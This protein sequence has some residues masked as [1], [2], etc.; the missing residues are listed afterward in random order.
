MEVDSKKIR[1][2]VLA[3]L[4]V[5]AT[6]VAL[7]GN[8][9]ALVEPV[10]GQ[11][12]STVAEGQIVTLYLDINPSDYVTVAVTDNPGYQDYYS[13][14]DIEPMLIRNGIPQGGSYN[15]TVVMLCEGY[16][17]DI[18]GNVGGY[19]TNTFRN[20][21]PSTAHFTGVYDGN[22][23]I[24]PM[25][26]L[27]QCPGD[28]DLNVSEIDINPACSKVTDELFA[29][30]TNTIC[31]T[32][33]NNGTGDASAFNVS[34]VI[35]GYRKVVRV[36]GLNA[37]ES[38]T[39]CID[40][41]HPTAPGNLMVNVTADCDSEV[42]ETDEGNNSKVMA[43][44]VYNN[45]YKGKRW[46]GG[47]DIVTANYHELRGN[48]TYSTGDSQYLSGYYNPDWTT[49]MVNWTAA[50]LPVPAGALIEKARLYL[51][52]TW[53]KSQGGN[54]TD[55]FSMSF[56]G[57]PVSAD[58]VY[59]DRKMFGSSDY[60]AQTVAYDVRGAFIP[61]APNHAVLTN[62]YP[63]GGHVSIYGM[64]LVVIYADSNEAKKLFW[65]NE[66]SDILSADKR[67]CVDYTEATAYAPFN[68]PIDPAKIK[69]ARLIS[70]VTAGDT[71]SGNKQQDRLY[72]NGNQ[73]GADVFN[74]GYKA[75]SIDDR[76]VDP[77]LLQPSNEV[78]IQSYDGTYERGDY[79]EARNAFL[80][81]EQ[82]QKVT[83]EMDDYE[84]ST[85]GTMTAPIMINDIEDYGAA[86]ITLSYDP[87]VVWVTE[88]ED[89]PFS[90]VQA[91][92]I[93]NTAGT[94]IISA[95]NTNGV[96]GDI[97]F[98]R[99]T[100]E[101]VGGD[102]A[103]TDLGLNV[104][105]LVDTGYNNL[106]YLVENGSITL[107][108]NVP[109]EISN[110]TANPEKIIQTIPGGRDRPADRAISTLSV[111]VVDTGSGVRCV[112]IDLSP[113]GGSAATVMSNTGGN[114]YSVQT[115][116]TEGIDQTHELLVTAEDKNG[117]TATSTIRLE[118]LR[119]G[120]VVRDNAVDMG[121]ALYIARYTV[122]LES[123]AANWVLV[124][125]VVG[126]AGDPLGDNAVDMA[127]ALYISR[128]T[129]GLELEP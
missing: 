19:Y 31:A 84:M 12:N 36:N 91:F 45:G 53:D 7:V 95:Q 13:F 73:I 72:F 129:V 104:Q 121:D 87:G 9:V 77:A 40:D 116:A 105:K 18:N 76:S 43:A 96:S 56:N 25:M 34:F 48:I 89:G 20:T 37:S 99:V 49:Y 16:E 33:W 68:G 29:N 102:G 14:S 21:T 59:A 63:G 35:D 86:T 27:E 107:K 120:D 128:Y 97:E 118:V 112:T 38:K 26:E 88:V 83:V 65:I 100:F 70:I 42:G 109:P 82:T 10:G 115:N 57:N 66:G 94:V 3:L 75:I 92:N 103:M 111:D 41:Y 28:P 17:R 101:A 61:N 6:F 2:G 93:D 64:L 1:G 22:P 108:E 123:E 8:A 5:T 78:S 119:R 50:D 23:E 60:P 52:T 81:L 46:T 30:E 51:Y 58:R 54:I 24:P 62:S 113:I 80:V 114:T 110:E 106:P 85:P 15:A 71:G 11:V 4:M 90:V 117:N 124:G 44:T 39:V 55:Y 125:D 69:S 74:G 127:D 98:A 67:Y 32:I 47:E 122:G 126:D 79:M